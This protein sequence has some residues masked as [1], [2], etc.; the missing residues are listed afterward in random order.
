MKFKNRFA[1]KCGKMR[2]VDPEV[3]FNW[4]ELNTPPP[5][6]IVEEKPKKRDF[7]KRVSEELKKRLQIDK[8][9]YRDKNGK[10]L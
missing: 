7:K 4:F 2:V 8:P 5:F 9:S 3:V 1:D 10:L 6:G